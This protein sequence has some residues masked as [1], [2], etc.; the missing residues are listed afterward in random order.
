MVILE[1]SPSTYKGKVTCRT[2][3]SCR[4]I[5][6][7]G[8]VIKVDDRFMCIMVPEDLP[9]GQDVEVEDSH[10]DDPDIM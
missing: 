4:R 10:V 5:P 8:I 6:E 9:M 1:C 2:D 3:R 7:E